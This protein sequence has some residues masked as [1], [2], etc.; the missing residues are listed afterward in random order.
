MFFLYIPFLLKNYKRFV[1]KLLKFLV[2]STFLFYS[3]FIEVLIL[4]AIFSI[5]NLKL[6]SKMQGE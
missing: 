4:S 3:F 1:K 2:I 6:L 5:A